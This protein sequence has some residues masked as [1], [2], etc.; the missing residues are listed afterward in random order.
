LVAI[1]LAVAVAA[2]GAAP[3]DT[4]PTPA[5]I[6][7]ATQPPADGGVAS[8][9]AALLTGTLVLDDRS[10]LGIAGVDITGGGDDV[11]PVR[12]PNGWMALE[13][14][15]VALVDAD[16]HAVARVGDRMALGGGVDGPGE[17]WVACPT[18]IKVVP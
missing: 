10:G 14:V 6:P 16:G 9:M 8:C 2:C 13:T 1:T 12:W 7:I 5:V 4:A 3:D 15:P 18:D 11:V 17:T